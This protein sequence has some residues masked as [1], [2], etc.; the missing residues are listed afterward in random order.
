MSNHGLTPENILRALPDVLRNDDNLYAL[1][2][3]VV[4]AMEPVTAETDLPRIYARID[5]LP[6]PLLDILAY[7]F[8]VDWWDYDYTIEQKRQTLKDSWMVHKHL[9]TPWAVETAI[10]AF[11]PGTKVSQ[12]FDYDGKPY[13]FR[14]HIDVSDRIIDTERQNRVLEL[15]NFYK[16]LR[17]RLDQV[18]Y[19]ATANKPAT[20]F[21]GGLFGAVVTIG[22]PEVPDEFDFISNLHM[23]GKVGAVVSVPVPHKADVFR[24]IDTLHTGGAVGASASIPLPEQADTL[25]SAD[26]LHFGG[27]VGAAASVPVPEQPDTI[28]LKETGYVDGRIASITTITMPDL[29]E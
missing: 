27:R 21:V 8:K 20:V 13:T 17:S 29:D 14:L 24:F 16:N 18:E 6:E 11:Y 15:V 1:A 9:G 28:I 3:A 2:E 19:T 26:T 5:D 4:A 23:G 12:W 25:R 7:D 10:S 22:I